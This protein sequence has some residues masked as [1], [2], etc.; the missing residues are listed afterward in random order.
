MN[1]ESYVRFSY[2]LVDEITISFMTHF[3]EAYWK[4]KFKGMII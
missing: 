4:Y 1:T 2:N 3:I